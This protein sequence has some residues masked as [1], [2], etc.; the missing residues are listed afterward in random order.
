MESR[1]EISSIW[2][3]ECLFEI[4]INGTNGTF[5]GQADCYTSR[6]EIEKLGKILEKFPSSVTDTLEFASRA[7]PDLSYFSMSGFCTDSCGHTLLA[8]TIAH[9]VSFTNVRDEN[10]KVNFDL[11]VEPQSINHFGRQLQ[12][13]AEEPIGT[14]EAVLKSAM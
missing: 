11:K 7:K 2:E 8:I 6:N 9:I 1:I 3:D 10:Y 12:R 13:I 5:A 4:R 14:T